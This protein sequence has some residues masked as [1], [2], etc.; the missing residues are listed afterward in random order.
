MDKKEQSEMLRVLDK[1]VAMIGVAIIPIGGLLFWQQYVQ[2]GAGFCDSIVSMVAAIVGMI[3]EGLYLLTSVALAVSVIRLSR[4]KVLVH[5]MKCIET[6][7]RVDVLCVDKTGTITEPDM[8]VSAMIPL[9]GH[10]PRTMPNL[11][12]LISDFAAAQNADNLT[13][14]AIKQSFVTP[15]K[16]TA[17]S[18]L[19]FS[20]AWKYSAVSFGERHYVLGAPELILRDEYDQVKNLVENYSADG[21]RSPCSCCQIRSERTRE[22]P[23]GTLLN[24]AYR[25]R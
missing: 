7:A 3:P 23:S 25:S 11:K 18:I 13:M 21:P 9:P 2:A 20:P 12:S 1:L 19:P 5:N 8:Q 14:Q 6:L 15:S 17:T 16:E 22:R 4:Q 10:D 24:R